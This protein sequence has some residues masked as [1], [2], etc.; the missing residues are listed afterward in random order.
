MQKEE[1]INT[2]FRNMDCGAVIIGI[3][4]IF[5]A[6]INLFIQRRHN[7]LSVKPMPLIIPF[8]YETSGLPPV[9]VPL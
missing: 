7:I 1:I 3:I 2:I 4:A 9:I 6:A 5:F 8:D